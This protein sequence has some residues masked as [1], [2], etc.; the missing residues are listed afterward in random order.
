M[1]LDHAEQ[2]PEDCTFLGLPLSL[3][4][5]CHGCIIQYTSIVAFA[6]LAYEHA[7]Y[8]VILP[9]RVTLVI[10]IHVKL[11]VPV[12]TEST[13]AYYE[14]IGCEFCGFVVQYCWYS[15]GEKS[16]KTMRLLPFHHSC[17]MCCRWLQKGGWVQEVMS[18][19]NRQLI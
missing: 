7:T 2:K 5:G 6:S 17:L 16:I 1:L 10:R 3:S 18:F 8:E 15:S 14:C 11:V 9:F 19:L 12:R 13:T 4:L